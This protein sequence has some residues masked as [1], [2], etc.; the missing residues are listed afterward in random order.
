MYVCMY[1][2]K[3]CTYSL[4]WC[5]FNEEMGLV[6]AFPILLSMSCLLVSSALISKDIQ[7]LGFHF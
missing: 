1:V 4:C 2:W 3:C 5:L 7:F 6:D